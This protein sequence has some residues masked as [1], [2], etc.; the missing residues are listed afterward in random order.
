MEQPD[1]PDHHGGYDRR[2]DERMGDAAM[3][4]QL[5]DRA[6]QGPKNVEVG[7]FGGQG[8]GQ[9]GVGGSAVQART[10]NAGSVRKWVTGSIAY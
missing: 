3:V 4:L 9:R 5:F 7:G 8:S 6:A 10:A 1:C 2:A